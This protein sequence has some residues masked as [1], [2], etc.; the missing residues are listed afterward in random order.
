MKHYKK[1][2]C[3]SCGLS[4]V[5]DDP[6]GERPDD[7]PGWVAIYGAPNGPQYHCP[8]CAESA[9]RKAETPARDMATR[10]AI[11]D[12]WYEEARQLAPVNREAATHLE[13]AAA[14]LKFADQRA[15]HDAD[16]QARVDKEQTE[17]EV[18]TGVAVTALQRG[19]VKAS[20]AGDAAAVGVWARAVLTTIASG[21]VDAVALAKAL[22]GGGP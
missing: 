17:R 18:R 16:V 14:R 3:T 8:S 21:D 1:L 10:D 22:L 9:L 6:L 5:F 2:T 7:A 12:R 13:E 19:L 15:R 4:A 20:G 11:A